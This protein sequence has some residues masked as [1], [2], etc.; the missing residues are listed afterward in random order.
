MAE[1]KVLKGTSLY[2]G[3]VSETHGK[4]KEIKRYDHSAICDY[5][6]QPVLDLSVSHRTAGYT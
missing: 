6:L 4:I 1:I 3:Y 5:S 2:T